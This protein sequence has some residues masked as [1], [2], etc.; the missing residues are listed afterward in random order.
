VMLL[1]PCLSAIEI[2]DKK[3]LLG[4][5][6]EQLAEMQVVVSASRQ[7]QKLSEVTVPITIITAEDIHYSG[8]TTIPE[9]LQFAPGVDVR[10]L[11]RQRYIVGVRGLFGAYSDRT[12]VLID[13]RP[14][15]D[16]IYGTTHWENLP[17]L[18]EDIARIEIAR[19]PVGAAWGANAFTGAINIITKKPDQC[20]GGLAS[21][22]I[23]EFG[24]SYTHLRY[25]HKQDKWTWKV[26]GGYE[27]VEDSDAAGAGR[28]ISGTNAFLNGLMGFSNFTAR[29]WGR[30]W[31]FDTQAE[32]QMNDKTKWSFGAAHT[33]GQQGD[34]EFI[35]VYPRRDFLT[36]YTRS[37]V[38]LDHQFD[39]DTTGYIQWFGDYWTS[40]RRVVTELTTYM[41]NDL[42]GQLTFK[43]LENHTTSIGGNVRWNR[44]A[45]HNHSS[46]DEF[47]LDRG[48]YNEYWAGVFLI[49][50]WAATNKL[51]LEGQIRLDYYNETTT[52]W[53]GRFTALYA[54]DEQRDHILRASF[55]RAFRAPDVGVRRGSSSYL[56][57][58]GSGLFVTQSPG[59]KTLDNE[60]TYALD[61]GYTG[62]LTE[63]LSIDVDAYYQRMERLI[64]TR[65][66]TVGAVTTSTF[67]NTSGANAYG[68]ETALTWQNKT[69]KISGWYAYNGLSTDEFAMSTRSMYTSQHKAGITGRFN[70]NKDWV[71]NTNYA[72][73]NCIHMFANTVKDPHSF[74]RLDLTLSRK[75]D[76]DK[77][78]IMVGVSDILNET[79][80]PTYG[81]GC[82]TALETPGRTVFARLQ[83][84]F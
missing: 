83:L 30:Y 24:D 69:T 46:T 38:R 19:S 45:S 8:A 3:D 49:D 28:Y 27:D 11:D 60:G 23:N 7:E 22:T 34:Y 16:P 52:D 70:L 67:D 73:Q 14:A 37:F 21:T 79:T 4:M 57:F 43:P 75:I 84:R 53:S 78:E 2:S 31:K 68:V 1:S 6:M 41:E 47:M 40:R 33:S 17:V 56:Q 62:K 10:R 55:A 74:N 12:L 44:L 5:D 63:N 39:K 26:S 32:Y 18:M 82:L 77:G 80:Y 9:I 72:F 51:T 15:M 59:G 61:A 66:V 58:F 13:G 81:A 48:V 36:E 64:G 50:R 71:L 42:E 29:D 25:G 54:L 20:L 65:N 76:D 35:G